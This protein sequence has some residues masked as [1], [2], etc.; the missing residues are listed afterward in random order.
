MAKKEERAPTEQERVRSFLK[1]YEALCQK[2]GFNIVVTPAFKA[3][4]D[5]TWSLVLQSTVGRVAQ[6]TNEASTSGD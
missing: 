5:G 2:H 1:G 3:R 6:P 4:D